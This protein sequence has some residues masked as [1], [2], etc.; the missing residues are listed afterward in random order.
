MAARS[1]EHDKGCRDY[2][3]TLTKNLDERLAKEAAPRETPK[4]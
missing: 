4:P 1:F 2:A 3:A